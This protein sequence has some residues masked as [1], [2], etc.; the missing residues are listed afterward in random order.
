MQ[1]LEWPHEALS[2][3]C[4]KVEDFGPHLHQLLDE[5]WKTMEAVTEIDAMALA[6]NQVNVMKRIF[7]MKDSSGVRH[8][9]INPE[10]AP[11]DGGGWANE[12]EGCLS[13]PGV[14]SQVWGR[15]NRVWLKTLNRKGQKAVMQA[16]G[17]DAVCIQHEIDHLDGIFW[18]ERMKRNPRRAAIREWNNMKGKTP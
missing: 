17:L 1:I 5:M 12:D 18:F 8:E 13:T 7:I 6:A 2:T 14:F 10:W 15:H 4:E 3:K 16:E 11:I 9:C